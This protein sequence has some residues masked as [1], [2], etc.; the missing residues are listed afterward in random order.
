M[1]H[2]PHDL[3]EMRLDQSEVLYDGCFGGSINEADL[4][5]RADVLFDLKGRDEDGQGNDGSRPLSL[6]ES[7][8]PD[9]LKNLENLLH[10]DDVA[11]QVQVILL[12]GDLIFCL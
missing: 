4:F 11:R 1:V 9:S 12:F 2:T 3:A 5:N 10:E 6:E 8:L 7:G